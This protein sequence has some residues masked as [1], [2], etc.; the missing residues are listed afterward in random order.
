MQ[1]YVDGNGNALMLT[2]DSTD[3]LAGLAFLQTTGASV[4]GT[5]V[6]ADT[7]A[8]VTNE[9]ELDAVGP[10]S[11]G[12]GTFLGFVTSTGSPQVARQL[13]AQT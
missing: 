4:S 1:L 6:M 8:D 13:R 9:F 5:Y 2:M 10:V 12:S 11:T 7:G 3:A